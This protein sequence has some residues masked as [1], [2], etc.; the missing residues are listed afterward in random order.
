MIPPILARRDAA[1]FWLTVLLTGIGTGLGASALTE[2]LE[3]VQH[4][5]WSGNGIDLL[6]AACRAAAWKHL[7]ILLGAGLLTGAGQLL[8]VRLSAANSIDITAA[9]WFHAGRLP[10]LRTLGSAMLSILVVGMGASLGREGAPKQTGAVIANVMSDRVRLSDEQRRLLV[11]CGSG[12]GMAAA[13]GVPLGGALFA[14]EVLRGERALRFV[15][16]ALLTSL[17]ATGVSWAFL[18]NAPTYLIPPYTGTLGSMVWALLAGPIIGLASVGYVRAV[19]WVDHHRPSGPRRLAASAITLT[20]LG[21]I[22][23]VFP[24]LLGNGRDIAQLAFTGQ[25][26]PLLLLSLL[27]LKPAATLLCLGSGTPG[28]LFTPS[29]AIGALLGGLLGVPFAHAWPGTAPGLFA[30]LGATA[31]L[32]ATTQGPLSATVLMMELT[33][34]A[35]AFIVPMLLI[36]ALATLI[37]RTI[38]PRSIYDAR[39][40]DAEVLKRQRQRDPV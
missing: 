11:A 2:L 27:L 8:V 37:A 13:Y 9:I 28:G 19:A 39:L 16:P 31:L 4:T 18:P 3:L 17:I 23:I 35:R 34:Q 5:L 14:L 32:A 6:Q 21:A 24:Q 1:G 15:L 38:E 22:S 25:V 12:A 7:V 30:V 10:T 29:L 20:L 36:V 26:A 40:S 33:G